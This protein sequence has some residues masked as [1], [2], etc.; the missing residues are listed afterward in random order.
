MRWKRSTFAAT[1]GAHCA[2]SGTTIQVHY[3]LRRR[4]SQL[5]YDH[6]PS[7]TLRQPANSIEQNVAYITDCIQRWN[8]GYDLFQP[9]QVAEDEWSAHRRNSRADADGSGR[10]SEFVDD[11]PTSKKPRCWSTLAHIRDKLRGQQTASQSCPSVRVRLR[12]SR[13][14][15]YSAASAFTRR[16]NSSAGRRLMPAARRPPFQTEQTPRLR[17]SLRRFTLTRKESS[18]LGQYG[19]GTFRISAHKIITN[20]PLTRRARGHSVM[21]H[22]ECGLPD[23]GLQGRRRRGR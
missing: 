5:L 1:M 14:A 8:R 7:G 13:L 21:I 12:R 2:R 4:L 18:S 19:V 23:H 9:S 15:A 22:G 6:R 17:A 11:G 20:T 3:G 10:Q 16:P